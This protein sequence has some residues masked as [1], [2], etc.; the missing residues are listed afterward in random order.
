MESSF[1]LALRLHASLML[2]PRNEQG[3][4]DPAMAHPPRPTAQKKRRHEAGVKLLRQ[5]SYRQETYRAV[6]PL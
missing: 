3:K 5:V 6:H 1:V 4:T 2:Q